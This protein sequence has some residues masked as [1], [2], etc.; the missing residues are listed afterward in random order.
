MQKGRKAHKQ[1]FKD[2]QGTRRSR[3]FKQ[4]KKRKLASLG[5]NLDNFLEKYI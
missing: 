4:N 1:S 3:N 5:K 2:A